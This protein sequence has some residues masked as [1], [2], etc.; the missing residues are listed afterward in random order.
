MLYFCVHICSQDWFPLLSL[1]CPSYCSWSWTAIFCKVRKQKCIFANFWSSSS[2]FKR[3]NFMRIHSSYFACFEYWLIS[4]GLTSL[5]NLTSLRVLSLNNN[6]FRGNDAVLSLARHIFLWLGLL[7]SFSVLHLFVCFLIICC[8]LGSL[9]SGLGTLTN[10]W[11]FSVEDNQFTGT[12]FAKSQN[13]QSLKVVNFF[14]WNSKFCWILS[15]CSTIKF[16]Q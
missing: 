14:R 6:L 2:S 1:N 7:Q 4:G 9:P 5:G 3:D 12:H 16:P 11:Q 8:S 15:I 13:G 10:L